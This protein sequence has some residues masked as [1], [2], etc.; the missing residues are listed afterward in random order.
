MNKRRRKWKPC[1]LCSE[2]TPDWDYICR[3]CRSDVVDGARMRKWRAEAL[4]GQVA[5]RERAYVLSRPQVFYHNS[6]QY[7]KVDRVDVGSLPKKIIDTLLELLTPA[8]ASS[9]SR[10]STVGKSSRLSYHDSH[11]FPDRFFSFEAGQPALLNKLLQLIR[12]LSL[13][14]YLE[15]KSKGEHFIQGLVNDEVSI[16]DL[17]KRQGDIR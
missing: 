5:Q 1:L 14:S 3:V 2:E 11:R 15:G 8:P 13:Y 12:Q 7:N 6:A 17:M 9:S 4:V 10:V 16:G